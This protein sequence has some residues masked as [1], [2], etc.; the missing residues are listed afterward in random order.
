MN[1]NASNPGDPT[2]NIAKEIFN[3]T[4]RAI[5]KELF[6]IY[7]EDKKRDMS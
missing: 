3:I 4:S 2:I 1:N 7:P 6:K 5:Y